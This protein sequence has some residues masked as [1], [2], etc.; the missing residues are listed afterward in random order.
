MIRLESDYDDV[1]STI[2][3]AKSRLFLSDIVFCRDFSELFGMHSSASARGR[4][5]FPLNPVNLLC[6]MLINA[7]PTPPTRRVQHAG[8]VVM[9]TVCAARGNNLLKVYRYVLQT[10]RACPEKV[11]PSSLYGSAV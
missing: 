3:A 2:R 4:S 1:D 10:T 9:A 8:R 5:Y 6:F 11:S 7:C